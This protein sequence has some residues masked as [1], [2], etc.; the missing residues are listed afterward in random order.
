METPQRLV[1]DRSVSKGEKELLMVYTGGVIEHLYE[2]RRKEKE[3]S[4]PLFS[5]DKMGDKSSCRCCC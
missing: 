2:K 5:A 3:R 4:F 1:N